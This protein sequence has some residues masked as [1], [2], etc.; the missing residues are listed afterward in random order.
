MSARIQLDHLLSRAETSI[1]LSVWCSA[2]RKARIVVGEGHKLAEG[3]LTAILESLTE[4]SDSLHRGGWR[5]VEDTD[6]IR[7]LCELCA[8]A[9]AAKTSR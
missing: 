3:H 5:E 6:G 2:C 7:L 1:S 8:E 4:L 9:A